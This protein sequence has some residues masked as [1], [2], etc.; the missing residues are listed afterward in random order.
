VFEEV[1]KRLSVS[2]QATQRFNV[3]QFDNKML[4]DVEIAEECQVGKLLKRLSKL[5]L[6][7]V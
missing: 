1:R 7:I 5:Q 2:K 6:K 4:Y 3:E